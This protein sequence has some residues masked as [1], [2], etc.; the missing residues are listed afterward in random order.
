M[1]PP[2]AYP[3]MRAPQ[4]DVQM[5]DRS[6]AG[7]A[8]VTAEYD[9]HGLVGIRLLDASPADVAAVAAQLGPLETPLSREPDIVIRF[10]DRLAVSAPLRLIGVGDAAFDDESFVILRG[11]HKAPIR[12]TVPFDSI[13]GGGRCEIQCEHG[14]PAVPLL[15]AIINLTALG[16]GALPVHASALRHEGKGVL[17]T[18]W[19]QG[20][21][22]ET[23]L[24]F[25]ANGAEYI[26]D[27]W[28]YL[29]GDGN[30]MC[31][32]PEPI[33]VRDWYLDELPGYGRRLS[34]GQRLRL[35][36]LRHLTSGMALL[37]GNGGGDG[38]TW[39]RGIRRLADVAEGQRYVH[40][41][42]R[43]TFGA[44]FGALEAA[45]DKVVFVACHSSAAI[46]AERVSGAEVAAR[47]AFSLQE[48]RSAFMS[49]YRKFRFAFPDK[50][51]AFIESA[52]DIEHER[53]RHAFGNRE[54]YAVH[55]PYP[56]SIPALFDA[57][58]PLVEA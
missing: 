24:G 36:A 50:R 27:E 34:R 7:D 3:A 49:C 11:K 25:L 41:A 37:A 23:L 43:E 57:V 10:V 1:I 39:R 14:A 16:K 51:N 54:C 58:R 42:P 47:M 29:T 45:V 46:T 13:A 22:T 30:R 55:H 5:E 32:I 56:V 44:G 17:V 33:R 21:K 28:I 40:L 31:G 26:G 52:D 15:I 9:L 6:A 8:S 18:G 35:R 53:L 48:E 4:A 12:V 38:T 2:V 20:G 19:S